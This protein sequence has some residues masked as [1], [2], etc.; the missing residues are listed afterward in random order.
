MMFTR[1]FRHTIL[2]DVEP[3]GGDGTGTPTAPAG[4]PPNDGQPPLPDPASA[5]PS[6]EKAET[7]PAEGGEGE[8]AAPKDGE[9]PE[10]EGL[11]A[12][13]VEALIDAYGEDF[14]NNPKFQALVERQAQSQVDRELAAMRAAP[15][16]DPLY[17][18]ATDAAKE[19]L[20]GIVED[21][22]KL[23]AGEA[24][25]P[26]ALAARVVNVQEFTAIGERRA[27]VVAE[28]VHLNSL[29][30]ELVPDGLDPKSPINEAY[31]DALDTYDQALENA[32]RARQS[33]DPNTRAQWEQMEHEAR[34]DFQ[35]SALQ[36]AIDLGRE[37]ER[38]SLTSKQDRTARARELLERDGHVQEAIAKLAGKEG[39]AVAA[40]VSAKGG[41]ADMRSDAEILADP[42]TP[43][44]K[45]QE[46]RARQRKAGG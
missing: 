16:S 25:D 13:T 8:P 37:L 40:G 30:K 19:S 41:G 35:L 32:H 4:P 14:E 11:S 24:V 20:Q 43:V 3:A 38:K 7:P 10:R 1:G 2:F 42:N 21:L 31:Q 28:D 39:A 45:L 26:Q 6:P 46:I 27:S 33:R 15:V 36:I 12:E 22:G 29:V 23:D 34:S 5:P 18:R 44:S 17:Q 9:T